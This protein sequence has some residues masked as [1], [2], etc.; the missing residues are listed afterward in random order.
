MVSNT[1]SLGAD[2]NALKNTVSDW[3][4]S[5]GQA[6]G[7]VDGDVIP[8]DPDT[9]VEMAG[10]FR[11][12]GTAFEQAGK[13]FRAITTDKWQGDAADAAREYLDQSPKEWL[14]AADAFTDAGKALD[15]YA[16][17]LRRAKQT[18]AAAKENLD[19]AKQAAENEA[20]QNNRETGV[21]GACR[22]STAEQIR[23]NQDLLNR[24]RQNVRGAAQDAAAALARASSNA[25]DKPGWM[26]RVRKKAVDVVEET[27]RMASSVA[28]GVGGA[29]VDTYKGLRTMIPA[30]SWNQTH[31]AMYSARMKNMGESIVTDP[32]GTLKQSVDIDGWKNDPGKSVGALI[33]SAVGSLAGGSGVAAKL[34]SGMG[35]VGKT[36]GKLDDIPT[37]PTGKHV[38][39][40]NSRPPGP[41]SGTEP[42]QPPQRP[43]DHGP[44]NGPGSQ[45]PP[46]GPGSQP[47]QPFGPGSQGPP[48]GPGGPNIAHRPHDPLIEDGFG[49]PTPPDEEFLRPSQL[50]GWNEPWSRGPEQGQEPLLPS[51]KEPLGPNA[52]PEAVPRDDVNGPESSPDGSG[53]QTPHD[54]DRSDDGRP[55][56]VEHGENPSP[57]RL[58]QIEDDLRHSATHDIDPA[59][60]PD[61]TVWRDSNEILYR[62]DDRE[63][64][65]ENGF[66]PRNPD[67]LDLDDYV[68]NNTESG[69]VS[70]A[71]NDE[72]WMQYADRQ[73]LYVT[74][75]PGGVVVNDSVPNHQ[76]QRQ[77]E[78]AQPGGTSTERVM[79]RYPMIKDPKT[80]LPVPSDV[81]EPNPYYRPLQ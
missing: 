50:D 70:W 19:E 3:G 6:V 78:I 30:D 48:S 40:G 52:R 25:P 17:V 72:I 63:D 49:V 35:K 43:Q 67:N 28:E 59:Q 58:R 4:Q 71:R 56:E 42:K 65:F 9:L 44:P 57:D 13:G 26:T 39:D 22:Q 12:M 5:I 23:A 66:Q 69:Y 61:N 79:G 41:D 8:G 16:Q 75:S 53:G 55:G 60:L 37:G 20:A 14:T 7:L 45:G 54:L 18:A 29:A 31:P 2:W 33:P 32:Y 47:S 76:F 15:E 34:A 51:D 1:S 10:H 64:V 73:Y 24:A 62:M 36:A 81:F 77:E 27:G 74:D 46:N 11:G 21:P 38:P 68:A 80:G